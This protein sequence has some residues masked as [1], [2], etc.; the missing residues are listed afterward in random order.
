LPA[1]LFA[2]ACA[3]HY[4]NVTGTVDVRDVLGTGTVDAWDW[5]CGCLGLAPWMRVTGT[6]HVEERH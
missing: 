4:V 5:H 3:G 1:G 2:S 6:V